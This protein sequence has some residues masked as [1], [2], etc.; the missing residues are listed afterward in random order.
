MKTQLT[1]T[2]QNILEIFQME[3]QW[4]LWVLSYH[5]THH[6]LVLSVHQETILDRFEIVCGGCFYFSGFMANGLYVLDINS[7]V[8]KDGDTIITIT[9]NGQEL[10]IK[11]LRVTL[12]GRVVKI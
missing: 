5:N 9:G 6:T 11:C 3:P 4:Y 1:E 2:I 7:V 12:K 8:D 10:L